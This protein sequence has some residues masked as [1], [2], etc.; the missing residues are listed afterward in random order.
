MLS[1]LCNV[2]VADIAL[3]SVIPAAA[4]AGFDAITVLGTAVRRSIERDGVG[5]VELT[6][7]LR[8]HALTVTD[9]EA[10]GD[11]LTPPPAGQPAWQRAGYDQGGFLELAS[12]LGDL[13]GVGVHYGAHALTGAWNSDAHRRSAVNP[14]TSVAVHAGRST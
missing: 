4:A 9:I 6:A 8:D 12:V 5:P 1:V 7:M 11:W 10:V 14:R 2:S 13:G 3:R